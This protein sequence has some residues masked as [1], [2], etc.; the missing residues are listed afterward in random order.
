MNVGHKTGQPVGCPVLLIG[1]PLDGR[2]NELDR[3]RLNGGYFSMGAPTM[4]PHSVQDPS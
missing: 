4:L 1:V 3:N 2:R